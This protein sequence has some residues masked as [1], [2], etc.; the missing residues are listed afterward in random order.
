MAMQSDMMVNQREKKYCIDASAMDEMRTLSCQSRNTYDG[1]SLD[2]LPG[3]NR[4]K[5]NARDRE[6]G[7]E[8]TR[9]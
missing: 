6:I 2:A 5:S 8:I 3:A 7:N 1:N 9:R 4:P